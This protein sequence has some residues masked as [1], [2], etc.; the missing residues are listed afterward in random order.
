MEAN[1]EKRINTEKEIDLLDLGKKLWTKRKFI[2]KASLVGLLIGVIVAFS[3]PKEYTTTVVLAPE[4]SSSQISGGAGT[5]AAMAGINLGG[6]ALDADIAPELYP[7]IVESTPFIVGLFDLRV[8]GIDNDEDLLLYSYIKNEQKS[9]WW[10]KIMKSPSVIVGLFSDTKKDSEGIDKSNLTKAQTLVLEDLKDRISL[11]VHKKTGVITLS[12]VMQDPNI[13]ASI[14]DTLISYLQSYI[15][16][17]RTQKARE[18]LAFTESLYLEAKKDYLDAQQKYAK[19]LDGNQ[20]VILASYRVTQEKLQNEMSL[21]YNVYNQVAQ[22]LQMA[23][24]K[25][26][27]ITPVYT[28]IQPAIVPLVPEK[29]NKKLIVV[30]FVFLT[31]IGA[32]AWILKKDYFG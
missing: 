18:D 5:L 15:I 20:D 21:T 4:A 8:K 17:Y 12:S 10:S 7:N 9:A 26:Q 3:I 30:G 13:S 32:C 16:S 24:V 2:L 29:P 28:V 19:Y 1:I 22:Q 11:S 31:L 23:K 14:A 25:V 6:A 27:D